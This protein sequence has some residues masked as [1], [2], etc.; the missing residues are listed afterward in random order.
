[1]TAAGMTISALSLYFL[2]T[3]IDIRWGFWDTALRLMVFAFGLGLGLAPLTNAATSTVPLHEV[4]VASSILAL[5]RNISGA[6]GVAI[7]AT[8]LTDSTTSHLI[9]L[10]T[11]SVI[12]TQDPQTLA[13][14]ASL[15]VTKANI[16]AFSTV[17]RVA[18]AMLAI[19]A[20]SALFVKESK[21]DF[22]KGVDKEHAMIEM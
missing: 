1:M 18:G 3:T 20:I 17:F 22:K 15:M 11:H 5:A 7:F 12:N 2:F 8:I 10:Q 4:G 6:F 13:K 21:R 19:G 14:A 16:L 9:A